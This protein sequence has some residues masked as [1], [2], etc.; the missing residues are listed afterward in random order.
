MNHPVDFFLSRLQNHRIVRS[1]SDAT[2]VP[3]NAVLTKAATG[4]DKPM[5]LASA[6]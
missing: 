4:R 5:P 6:T 2:Q 1:A 3:T